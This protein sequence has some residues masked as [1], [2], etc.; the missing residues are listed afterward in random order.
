MALNGAIGTFLGSFEGW[1][2]VHHLP[3]RSH[4]LDNVQLKK[5]MKGRIVWVDVQVKTVGLSLCKHIVQNECLQFGS[6]EIGDKFEG[7]VVFPSELIV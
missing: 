3:E 2:G 4:S 6:L 5:K 1:V 7:K